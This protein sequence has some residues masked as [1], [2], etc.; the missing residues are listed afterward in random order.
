MIKVSVLVAVYNAD[1]YLAQCIESLLDQS[2]HDIEVICVDDASTDGSL[3]ILQDYAAKDERI[4]VIHLSKNGGQAHARNVALKEARG[5]YVCFLDS[6]DWFAPDSLKTCSDVLDKYPDTDSVLF[7]L[8]MY[9]DENNINEYP[10]E[11]F[12]RLTGREAFLK[13]LNWDI[14]GVYMIR[15]ALHKK[16]PYDDTEKAYSDD[17]TSRIHY[18]ASR[19]VRCSDAPYYYRQHQSSVTHAVSPLRFYYMKANESMK[20]QLIALGESKEII[21][22]YENIRWLVLIDTY[23]FYYINRRKLGREAAHTGLKEMKRIWSGIDYKVLDGRAKKFGYRP[24]AD[25]WFLFR[26]QEELYFT[27]RNI[28]GKNEDK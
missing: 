2:L 11:K 28:L 25:N 16:Y 14:H 9:Y 7:R 24:F 19:N 22:K 17:N 3:K 10:M 8:M 21:D 26:L 5:E 12:E 6:D 20:R 18:I 13:S 15:T 1:G 4:K 27:I 23:M